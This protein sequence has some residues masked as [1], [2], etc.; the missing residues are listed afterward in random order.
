MTAENNSMRKKKLTYGELVHIFRNHEKDETKRHLTGAIVFTEDS[1]TET[2][3]L[4]SRTYIISSNNKAFMPNMLGYSIYGS[5]K[6][7]TDPMVRLESVM[8]AEKGG[9]K[10]WKVDYCYLI[11]E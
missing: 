3:S 5:S 8:A 6:D 9:P 2:Y 4:E 11:D 1:F 10:G 7:G